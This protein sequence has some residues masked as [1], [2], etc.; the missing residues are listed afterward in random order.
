MTG[1]VAQI[2]RHPIKS[3]GREALDTVVLTAGQTMPWDRTWAVTHQKSAADGTAWA[4]CANFSISSRA[5][6]LQAIT[7]RMDETSGTVCLTHPDRPELC[8]DPDKDVARFLDWV[9]PLMP[10][11]RAGS[12]GIV[13]VP[14]RGMTDTDYP[15]VSLINLSSSRAVGQQL[16][17]EI[18]ALRW[19]GN[20]LLDGLQPWQEFAWIGKRVRIGSAELEVRERIK[21]CK[22]TMA[23]PA[24]GIRD[25]E[26]LAALQTGWQHTEF[27][28]YAEVVRSGVIQIGD[29]LEVLG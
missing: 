6:Q 7:A 25:A 1:A 21:R 19:R 10:N 14:G 4:P 15:S 22:A 24:T 28:V 23:N 18:S 12:A 29:R 9:S 13:R 11:D 2:W 8:F 16:G 5:P 26:T 20:F 27:G 3:H 17:Q